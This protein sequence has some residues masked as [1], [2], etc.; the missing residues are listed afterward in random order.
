MVMADLD[1]PRKYAPQGFHERVRRLGRFGPTVAP[2][3]NVALFE[4]SVGEVA[5]L[6]AYCLK[7][8]PAGTA[9]RWVKPLVV[10]RLE[11]LDAEPAQGARLNDVGPNLL[12]RDLASDRLA[13]F[14]KE[15]VRAN[16]QSRGILYPYSN[17][18]RARPTLRCLVGTGASHGGTCH[19]CPFEGVAHVESPAEG[20]GPNRQG[21]VVAS[22][23]VRRFPERLGL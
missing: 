4:L 10:G 5:S 19:G 17:L 22:G 15:G 11:V 3:P 14:I 16:S 12:R 1:G 20:L 7:D 23:T 8:V 9:R 18:G 13:V 2:L 6:P 21:T